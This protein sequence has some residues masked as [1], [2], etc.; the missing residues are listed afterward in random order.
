MFE[1]EDEDY[2]DD[3]DDE[4]TSDIEVWYNGNYGY[5]MGNSM[6][7]YGITVEMRHFYTNTYYPA[8]QELKPAVRC[9]MMK[10]YPIID[11]EFRP[12]VLEKIDQMVE[13]TGQELLMELYKLVRDH[14]QGVN[15]RE[16]YPKFERWVD[17]YARP[18]EVPVPDYAYFDKHP[19]RY[20]TL[21]DEQKK[22]MLEEW[23]ASRT[24]VQFEFEKL[25][26]EYYDLVQPVIF[27]YYPALLE[28]DYEG[29]I[30][31]SVVIRENYED[32]IVRSEHLDSFID[33]EFP[34]ED[35]DLPYKDLYE[36]IMLK[37]RER[38]DKEHLV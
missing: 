13:A 18:P 5:L 32:Y 23:C 19:K 38:W 7:E 22:E 4:F 3:F 29:W 37:S 36:K 34:E 8:M 28:L 26:K 33:Y 20:R 9:Q 12:K 35:I 11:T 16:K 30:L 31:Y 14:Q 15:L 1:E 10:Q 27:N 24:E 6:N 21:T 2:D 25:K 17:F